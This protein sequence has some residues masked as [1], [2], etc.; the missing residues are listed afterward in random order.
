[1]KD[2]NAENAPPPSPPPILNRIAFSDIAA[3]LREGAADFRRAPAFGLF[4]T[5][6]YVVGGLVI[7]FQ[8]QVLSQSYWVIP[9][10]LGFPLLGPFVAVGLY[11]VS[12]RLEAGEPLDWPAIIGVVFK[13]TGRQIPS[14]AMVVIMIFL[15]WIYAA[16]LVFALFFGLKA[17]TNITT[18]WQV[19]YSVDG[20]IMLAVG[21]AVGAVLSFVLFSITVIGLPLLLDREIDVVSAMVASVRS[22]LENAGPML[23]FGALAGAAMV[24][25]MAP[26]FLGLFLVLPILGHATWR[27]YRKAVRFEA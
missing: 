10:A 12:R 27:L 3:A 2:V 24:V 6:F 26:Y 13:Q 19:L 18:S 17:M 11:E 21:T 23:A 5:A 16:H 14:L 1:M 20:A 15:F 7:F 25:G 8:L 4:F 22:V 9:L